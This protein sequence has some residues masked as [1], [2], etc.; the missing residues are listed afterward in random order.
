MIYVRQIYKIKTMDN[1]YRHF[2]DEINN[3]TEKYEKL[4]E[5]SDTVTRKITQEE[6]DE[7]NKLTKSSCHKL[8]YKGS[9]K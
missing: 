5:Q 7:Y 3:N 4:N 2:S 8:K 6:I 1:W 9:D